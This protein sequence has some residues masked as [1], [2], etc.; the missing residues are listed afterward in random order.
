MSAFTDCRLASPSCA[1][2]H[3]A[4]PAVSMISWYDNIPVISW[5]LLRGRCRGC[6][7]P[8]S[9][10]YPLV[11]LLTGLLA[12]ITAAHFGIQWSALIYFIFG[13]ALIVITFIDL[14][15]ASFRTSSAYLASPWAS[16][17]AFCCPKSAG[18]IAH[19]YRRRR[20][21]LAGHRHGRIN[22]SRERRAWGAATSNCWP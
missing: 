9:I 6:N 7:A 22:L 8:I 18:G 11:E 4:P 17:P 19:R 10:R 20:G 21:Q 3:P 2:L 16:W 13:V 14:D 15:L 5:I 12:V 1:R